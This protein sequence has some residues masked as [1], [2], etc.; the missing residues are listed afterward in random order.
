MGN[1]QDRHNED[2][3]EIHFEKVNKKQESKPSLS[4]TLESFRRNANLDTFLAYARSNVQDTIAYA[5]LFLGL[6]LSIFQG[7]L[8]DLLVGLVVGFY[9]SRELLSFVRSYEFFFQEHGLPRSVVFL[10]LMF[11][12]FI[13][14]PGVFIGAAI[15]TATKVL[16]RLDQ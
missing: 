16:L 10:A 12:L 6:L 13:S 2:D 3:T 8:G 5:V 9:F 15:M 7:F 11:V 1:N 14:A 4:E